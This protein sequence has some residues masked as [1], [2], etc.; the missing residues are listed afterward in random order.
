MRPLRLKTLC[1]S[2]R[3]IDGER[4]RPHNRIVGKNGH[5][6]AGLLAAG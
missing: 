1:V 3:V 6:S 5:T 2:P 4:A